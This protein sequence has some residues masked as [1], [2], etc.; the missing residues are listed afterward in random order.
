MIIIKTFQ[1]LQAVPDNERDRMD[2]VKTVISEHKSSEIYKNA[3]IAEQYAKHRNVTINEF[4]KLLYTVSGRAIPDNWSANFKMA[5]RHFYRFITQENQYLLSN[6]VQWQNSD[7]AD[8]LG[9]NRYPFD[10]QLQAA[11]KKALIGGVSF[12]F[13]N[14]DHVDIFAITEF[15]PILDE[16]DGAIK[17]G[18]RFWQICEGKPLRATLYEIDGYTDFIWFNDKNLTLSNEWLPLDNGRAFK[19]K[20]AY[21]LNVRSSEADGDMIFDGENYPSFPIIP[22]WGNPEH[23]S[24]IVGLR[25][26]IDCYDL[27]K[28]GYANNV[29]E[30]S[31]VYWTLTNAGGMDDIDLAQFVERIKTVHATTLLDDVQAQSHTMDAPYQSREALL[32]RLDKDLY[33]DAMALDTDAFAIGD[34]TATQI[35]AAYEALNEK[36]DMYEYCVID[37]IQGILNIA[38]IEDKPTFTR[39]KV[40]NVQEEIQTVI[41]A[42]SYLDEE[43]VTRKILA[44]FGD[45]DS[46]DEVLARI[47]AE[48]MQRLNSAAGA[49]EDTTDEEQPAENAE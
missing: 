40:I 37:F 13:Y 35:Q 48:N 14:L 8:K 22:F 27:I 12:G 26:Q 30:A 21:K 39:S 2:F 1:D 4:Q 17:S 5:C 18:V 44:L 29:D 46:A 20:R 3:V 7:T 25:E 19:P 42:A 6:G 16:E 45:G 47:D 15:A 11:G 49:E 23:Q 38:G 32:S 33:R 24:E 9:N 41:Q 31:L 28:S 36:C 34:V 43:Y 10:S